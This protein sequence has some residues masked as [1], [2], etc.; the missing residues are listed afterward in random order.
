MGTAHF[1][2]PEQASSE[3]LDGRSDFYSLGVVGVSRA[4]R[5]A[6]VRRADAS[7]RCS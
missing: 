4:Q 2:S 5:Q 6:A 7:R 3:P 1:M